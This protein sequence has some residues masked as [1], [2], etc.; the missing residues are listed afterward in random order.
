M[1]IDEYPGMGGQDPTIVNSTGR[2][3][4][5]FA[6]QTIYELDTKRM[7]VW[8]G[9]AWQLFFEDTGWITLPLLNGWVSYDSTYGPPR[10]RRRNGTVYVQGLAKNGSVG[11]IMATLPAGF[12]PSMPKLL[13]TAT[14]G[15]P[16]SHARVDVESTGNIIHTG[17]QNGWFSL[18]AII[19]PADQ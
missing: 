14:A 5:P 12:R 11:S 6:G 2:P 9:A 16:S 8:D 15:E 13:F 4:A 7:L 3:S 19:F 1:S 17:S 10:Y 18:S